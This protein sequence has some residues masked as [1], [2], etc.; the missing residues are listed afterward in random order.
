MVTIE[1]RVVALERSVRRSKAAAVALSLLLV[2]VICHGAGREDDNQVRTRRLAIVNRDGHEVVAIS[3]SPDGDGIMDISSGRGTRSLQL[4]SLAD[5][6]AVRVCMGNDRNGVT[7]GAVERKGG[8]ILVYD[9]NERAK[10]Q[11]VSTPAGGAVTVI[12]ADG[13]KKR[14]LSP[15]GLS[16]GR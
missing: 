12:D 14:I 10:V 15:F 8:S 1:D 16:E 9:E 11:A 5:G 2:A 4:V 13:R 7:I 6:G 3:S